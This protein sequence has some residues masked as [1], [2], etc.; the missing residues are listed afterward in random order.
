MTLSVGMVTVDS[1][2]ALALGRWWAE[3]VGGEVVQENEGWFVVVAVPGAPVQLAFQKVERPTPGK[4]KMHLD[5]VATDLD[6]EVSRLEAAGA[7]KVSDQTME[8]GFRWVTLA[9]PEGNYFD[10]AQAE[11]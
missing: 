3:Q 10:V 11:S 8:T 1:L 6:A 9:D 5:L 4:N 7:D 2:D